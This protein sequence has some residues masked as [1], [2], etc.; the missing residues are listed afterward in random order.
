MNVQ[1][2]IRA[3]ASH[4]PWAW[5]ERPVVFISDP[6]ADAEGFL[7]S[8][9]AAGT[10]RRTGLGIRAFELTDFGHRAQIVIGGDCLDKGPS[11][12]DLL[13]AIGALLSTDAD[14][15]LLAGNHDLRLFVALAALDLPRTSLTE[16][17]FVRM[18]RKAI[19]LL[20]EISNRFDLTDITA[21]VPDEATCRA[22][23]FPDNDWFERFPAEA[24]GF[25]SAEIV[26]KELCKMDEKVAGFDAAI[27][28]AGL[29]MRQTYAAIMQ[30][31]RLFLDE[32]GA[33]NWF[34]QQMKAVKRSGSLLFV[35]AGL[36]DRMSQMLAEEGPD[37]V[38]RKF[39]R[40]A[41]MG[42]FRFYTG[43][44]ANMV[45][46]KYRRTDKQLTSHGVDALFRMG[47]KMV[48]QGHVNN[49]A[50]QRILTKN[51]LLH[52]EGDV[53]LD[54]ASRA[55]EGLQGIGVGATLIYPSG[56]VVGLSVD[57][58]KAKHFKPELFAR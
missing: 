2:S 19:P 7:R 39:L 44:V 27:A 31:R 40:D 55:L 51:G 56:D 43:E 45:R 33:Y 34:F 28:R 46:T 52:L 23:L 41:H 54:R 5:P 4:G 57:Y 11:N 50:G 53:T 29:T 30:C 6:H 26:Q 35:H 10:I 48:V 21:S 9:V 32:T 14:V 18:A 38:N 16:H 22:K 58:P 3:A 24:G 42:P 17:L 37:A 12:L 47:I 8:L 13:D 15:H 36:C 20:C 25:L 49:H 1:N